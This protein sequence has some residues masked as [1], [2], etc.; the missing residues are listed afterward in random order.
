MNNWWA[1]PVRNGVIWVG[2]AGND[3]IQRFIPGVVGANTPSWGRLKTT[4]R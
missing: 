2:E 1:K 3:R 4:Y